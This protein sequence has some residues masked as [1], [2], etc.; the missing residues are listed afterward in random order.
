LG[1]KENRMMMAMGSRR[2]TMI[3]MFRISRKLKRTFFI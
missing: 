1:L 3:R 2:Y